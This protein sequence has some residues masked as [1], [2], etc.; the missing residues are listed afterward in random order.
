MTNRTAGLSIRNGNWPVFRPHSSVGCPALATS[1]AT[2]APECDAPTTRTGPSRSWLG[3]RYSL[4][5]SCRMAGS[6]SSA[7]SGVYGRPNVPDATTT[8]S[9][10]MTWSAVATAYRP[11]GRDSAVT[12]V[13][14][15]TGRSNVWAYAAR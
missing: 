5:C 4:E 1:Y 8:L 3:L 9:A 15:R 7:K 10:S 11:F 6:R 2:S 13:L 14:V 12:A